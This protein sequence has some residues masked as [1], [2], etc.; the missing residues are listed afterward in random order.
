MIDSLIENVESNLLKAGNIDWE[1][2][3]PLFLDYQ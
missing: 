2:E 1:S 3:T